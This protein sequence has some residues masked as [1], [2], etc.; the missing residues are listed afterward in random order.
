MKLY[1]S[2]LIVLLIISTLIIAE[3]DFYKILGVSKSSSEKDIKKAYKKGALKY[4]PDKNRDKT[5]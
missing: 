2:L 3:D 5:E 4:H 1:N